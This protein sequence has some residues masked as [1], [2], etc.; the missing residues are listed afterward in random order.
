MNKLIK[1]WSKI[2]NWYTST[3][4][5]ITRKYLDS[6]ISEILNKPLVFV[7]PYILLFSLFI[8][9]PTI[10]SVVLSLTYFNSVQTPE[11][12]GFDNYVNLFTTDSIFLQDAIGTTIKYAVIV[13]PL[14]YI[15]SF[16]LAWMLGQ[17]THKARI[18]YTLMIFS[19]SITGGV[20]M[21]V[22]W[23]VMFSGDE[24]GYL[25]NL[26]LKSG[27]VK[28]PIIFL[29]D[30]NLLFPIMILIALWSSAGVGFLAMSAGILNIDRTLYE[31]AYIDGI[32]N[33]W[34]EIYYITIPMMKPQMLFGAVMA[35]VNAFNVA[36]VASALSGGNPPPQ[37]VGWMVMDHANDF[38]FA[39][40][41][42]GYASAITVM[43]F[44][45]IYICNRISY[46]LFGSKD[47]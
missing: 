5:I 6:R 25:N 27:I 13:G 12:R 28:D 15:L 4:N 1:Q 21:N 42:M 18:I 46:K 22:V 10:I 9:L 7:M 38:G 36:G 39:R 45:I 2:T 19:P 3:R 47:D 37:Y 20:M 24:A 34:Q 41:E 44:V 8:L 23:Q 43:L 14:G 32:K 29:Q 17:V 11:W 40:Y 26:L 31:A 33:R 16:L 30:T 35:I